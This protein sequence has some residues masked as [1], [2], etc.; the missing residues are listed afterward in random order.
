M[1]FKNKKGFSLIEILVALAILAV[2]S[3]ILV[4]SFLSISKDSKEAKDDIKFNS[5]SLAFEQ[6]FSNSE[7]LTY[8]SKNQNFKADSSD[9]SNLVYICY[10]VGK[11]GEINLENG[12]IFYQN[13]SSKESNYAKSKVW[14]NTYQSLEKK[15]TAEQKDHFEKILVF[16][17]MPKT[18]SDVAWCEYQVLEKAELPAEIRGKLWE[19]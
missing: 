12:T 15:Y 5:I 7:V 1:L 10:D 6:T 16:K 2:L 14:L 19:K 3:V 4:P 8:L 17:V 11:K 18:L 13:G 9:D